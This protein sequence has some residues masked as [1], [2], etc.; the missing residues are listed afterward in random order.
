LP[1]Q[2]TIA[3]NLTL[4]VAPLRTAA[5]QALSVLTSETSHEEPEGGT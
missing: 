1:L 5:T 2:S 3:V 4:V